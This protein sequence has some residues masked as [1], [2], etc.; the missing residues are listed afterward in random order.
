M[1]FIYITR[2]Y[3][4]CYPASDLLDITSHMSKLKNTIKAHIML[5]F[6]IELNMFTSSFMNHVLD[7]CISQLLGVE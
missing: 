7:A 1:Y 6:I 3:K 4:Q 2:K 5:A